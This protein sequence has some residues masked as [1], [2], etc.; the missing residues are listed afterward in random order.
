MAGH[1][2]IG[3]WSPWGAVWTAGHRENGEWYCYLDRQGRPTVP[4]KGTWVKSA[5]HLPRALM[6]LILL[7]ERV[8]LSD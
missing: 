6:K 5:F 4:D 1:R 3:E 2:E 7:F 8:G